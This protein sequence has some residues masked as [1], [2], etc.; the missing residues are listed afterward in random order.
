MV[1]ATQLPAPISS[2]YV[3]QNIAI[4]SNSAFYNLYST[5]SLYKM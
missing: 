2:V 4:S 1:Q 3:H 5:E